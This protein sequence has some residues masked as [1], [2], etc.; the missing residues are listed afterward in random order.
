MI[1]SLKNPYPA[2]T[3]GMFNPNAI[4]HST[5]NDS[6]EACFKFILRELRSWN[7]CKTWPEVH[8]KI[9]EFRARVEK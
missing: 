4:A 3:K 5:W 6:Q 7:K 2:K 1:K 8:I 9:L